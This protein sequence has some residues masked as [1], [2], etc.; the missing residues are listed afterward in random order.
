MK[1]VLFLAILFILT[2]SSFANDVPNRRIFIEGI[3]VRQD[4]LSF[5]MTTF[6][7]E[8]IGTGYPT[9]TNKID[10]AY[11]FF[12]DIQENKEPIDDNNYVIKIILIDNKDSEE[13]LGFD[14]FFSN[15]DDIYEYS[16][17][18]FFRACSYIPHYTEED[19][20]VIEALDNRWKNKWIYL[21]VSFDYP[22]RFYVLQPEGLH[23]GTGIYRE[24]SNGTI[25]TMP[26]HH[27][28][29][30]LPGGTFGIEFQLLNFFSI[31]ANFQF[32]LGDPNENLFYNYAVGAEAKI[33]LKFKNIMLVPYGAFSYPLNVSTVYNTYPKF[34]VGGGAQLCARGGKH[35]AFFF[36]L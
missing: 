29:I 12:F 11:V 32:F 35:G 33:P 31:E 26:L 24:N 10:A 6:Q 4:F 21:R 5:F 17:Y 19:I 27:E 18:L 13:V 1:K 28:L 8:A 9:T 36:F 15:T 3:S 16:Q 2:V 7:E 14:F 23:A 34:A 30:A 22:I 20:I 25:E